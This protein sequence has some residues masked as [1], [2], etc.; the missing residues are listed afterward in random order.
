[1]THRRFAAI[2]APVALATG[3]A[4][5]FTAVQAQTD[6]PEVFVGGS[7]GYARLENEEVPNSSDEVNDNRFGYGLRAGVRFSPVF[8]LEG[9][10][11]D[12]GEA[13]ENGVTYS[14]DGLTLAGT[15]HIPLAERASVYGKLGQLFWDA[16]G[17]TSFGTFEDDG[18]DVFYGVGLGLPVGAATDLRFEYERF[19]LDD[20]DVDQASIGLDVR[21]GG[22]S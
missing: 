13:E 5:P 18:N 11:T 7:I 2:A 16:E 19:A 21:F 6:T 10:Y 4:M 20:A 1:M 12:F 17:R 3:M 8:G 9:G 15:V 22:A 14:A